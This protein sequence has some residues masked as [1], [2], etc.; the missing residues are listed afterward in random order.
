MKDW[1]IVSYSLSATDKTYL[2][3]VITDG[4]KIV[5]YSFNCIVNLFSV[6]LSLTVKQHFNNRSVVYGPVINIYYGVL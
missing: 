1:N 2:E 5:F 4:Q 3:Y 6:N